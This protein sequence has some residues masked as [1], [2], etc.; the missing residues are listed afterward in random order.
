MLSFWLVMDSVLTVVVVMETLDSLD[1]EKA[2][3]E[4]SHKTTVKVCMKPGLF[5]SN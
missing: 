5:V 1:D 3:L 2:M 4:E